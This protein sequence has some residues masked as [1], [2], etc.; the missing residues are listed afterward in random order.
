VHGSTTREGECA[1]GREARGGAQAGARRVRRRSAGTRVRGAHG[2][3]VQ[4]QESR[5]N[6][7][8]AAAQNIE[9]TIRESK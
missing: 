6:G 8:C 5:E 1:C 7:E 4:R 2:G 9:V 3:A